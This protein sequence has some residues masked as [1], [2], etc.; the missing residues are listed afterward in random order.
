MMKYYNKNGKQFSALDY[1][2]YV[3]N[4][5]YMHYEWTARTLFEF[6]FGSF[7]ERDI[8]NKVSTEVGLK[9][10]QIK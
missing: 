4:T 2:A 8:I 7:T 3:L 6:N 1:I 10:E 5:S 9:T